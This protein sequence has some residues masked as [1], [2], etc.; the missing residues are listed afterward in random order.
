MAWMGNPGQTISAT[1]FAALTGVSRERLR[2]WERRHGFPAPLR[3]GDG[4]RRYA[5]DDV[6]RVV[7]IR[8]AAAEG[9]PIPVAIARARRALPAA[10]PVPDGALAAVVEDLPTPVV[11]LSGPA[12]MR[13]AYANGA[14]RALPGAPSAGAE[15]ISAVPDFAGSVAAGAIER[16]FATEAGATEVH[17][18]A[19]GGHARHSTRSTLFRLPAASGSPPLVAMVGLEGEGERTA[20]AALAAGRLEV[21][22]LRRARARHTGWL[23]GLARLGGALAR[24]S[25]PAVAIADALDTVLAQLGAGD[26]ALATHAHGRL[27]LEGSRRGLI[28]PGELLVAAHPA[29]GRALGGTQPAWLDPADAR[30]WTL[31]SD[32]RALAVP[33]AVAGE[34]LGILVVLL[35]ALDGD[36]RRLLTVLSSAVGFALLRDR[37]VH[38][39]RGGRGWRAG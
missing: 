26:V 1:S 39:L 29:L 28:A 5:V 21:D 25:E 7:A 4:P 18:P 13:I 30:A 10:T 6:Q 32:L 33:V 20:R 3:P 15:L 14:V 38:E 24:E 12:P 22:E 31:P 2:T 11:V 16:L 17:H 8:H 27:A 23:E 19:W 37:L 9:V 35:A 36:D 34:A